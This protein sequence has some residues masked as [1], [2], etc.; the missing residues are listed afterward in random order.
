M[1]QT[2]KTEIKEIK[3]KPRGFN[4]VTRNGYRPYFNLK[5]L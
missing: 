4:S 2:F 5:N 1:Q 3:E